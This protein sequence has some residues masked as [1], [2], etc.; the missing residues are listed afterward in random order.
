MGAESGVGSG[1]VRLR[2]SRGSFGA[3]SL[4]TGGISRCLTH[5]LRTCRSDSCCLCPETVVC[6]A[7]VRATR[8]PTSSAL[9]PAGLE[10]LRLLSTVA[11][12]NLF[13]SHCV[14][15]SNADTHTSTLLYNKWLVAH[16][17]SCFLPKREL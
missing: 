14:V 17:I 9:I 13:D 7:P 16:I 6:P 8:L 11:L 5:A 10:C 2:W 1:S 4:L 3:L 15:L 12:V